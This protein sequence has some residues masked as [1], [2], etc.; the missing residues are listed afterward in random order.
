[1]QFKELVY[2][3]DVSGVDGYEK[4]CIGLT[5]N[6][7]K[8][9]FSQHMHS[10]RNIQ[11]RNSTSLSKLFWNLKDR[12]VTPI[13]KWSIA[14]KASRYKGGRGNCNL[15]ATEKLCILTLRANMLNIREETFSPCLHTRKFRIESFNILYRSE[16]ARTGVTRRLNLEY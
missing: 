5:G 10:F 7:F 16:F 11:R 14:A 6:S 8:A 9:R 15:C 13:I 2:R 4:T 1:M 12:G 3:A